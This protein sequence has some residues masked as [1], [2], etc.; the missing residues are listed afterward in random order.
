MAGLV[1]V[2]WVNPALSLDPRTGNGNRA[3]RVPQMVY[4]SQDLMAQTFH[5][6]GLYRLGPLP[7]QA[8]PP[9]KALT[10]VEWNT[11]WFLTRSSRAISALTQ[12][13]A[14]WWLSSAEAWGA[15]GLGECP[16]VVLTRG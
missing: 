9:A 4:H 3:K 5:L 13:I 12:D 14:S 11:I 16:V 8:P 1:L 6:V 10:A 7:Q 15:G 2:N